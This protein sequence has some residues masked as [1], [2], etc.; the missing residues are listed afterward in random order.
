MDKNPATLNIAI[1]YMKSAVAN[2][3]LILHTR[4]FEAKGPKSDRLGSEGEMPNKVRAKNSS[5]NVEQT[6]MQHS[7]QTKVSE[8]EIRVERKE[9][10][11]REI[12]NNIQNIFQNINTPNKSNRPMSNSQGNTR[13][14]PNYRN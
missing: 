5:K 9:E 8:L 3:T 6:P 10:V 14:C 11:N 2:Q 1:Q 12:K 7:E 4:K 13:K